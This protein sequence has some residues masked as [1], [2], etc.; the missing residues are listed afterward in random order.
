MGSDT[1]P[2]AGF[3]VRTGEVETFD[4]RASRIHHGVI[5]GDAALGSAQRDGD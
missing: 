1:W 4:S 5:A 2:P 3:D